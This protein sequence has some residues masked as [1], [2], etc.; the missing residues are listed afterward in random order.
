MI[1]RALAAALFLAACTPTVGPPVPSASCDAAC[2]ALAAAGCAEGKA[3]DCPA[4]LTNSDGKLAMPNGKQL[5]CPQLAGVKSPS[6]VEALG[7]PCTS[8]GHVHPHPVNC[9]TRDEAGVLRYAYC[10]GG[11]K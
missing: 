9:I 5:T 8:P 6:D 2:A 4:T 11:A 3:A 1:A 7:Q 10:D